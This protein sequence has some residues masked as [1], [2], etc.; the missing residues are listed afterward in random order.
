MT[1]SSTLATRGRPPARPISFG[2]CRTRAH[3]PEAPGLR[4]SSP[5]SIRRTSSIARALARLPVLRK[6]DLPA[7][8][9][10][11]RPSAASSPRAPGS[12][13]AALHLARADLRAGGPEA[14]PWRWARALLRGRP[15]A[16][17]RRPQQ[18]QLSPDA[19]RVRARHRRA[20]ARLRGDSGG[21]GQHRGATRGD[22]RATA[23]RFI[24][25]PTFSSLLDAAAA[26]AAMLVPTKRASSQRRGAFRHPSGGVR[27][28]AASRPT[29]ATRRPISASSPTR[30]APAKG[31]SSTRTSFSKSCG[32][33]P[34]I[35]FRTA[36]SAKSSLLRSIRTIPDPSRRRRPYGRAAGAK[37]LRAH[38]SAHQGLD[39]PR[40]PDREGQGHVRPPRADR[41]DRAPPSGSRPPAPRRDARGRDR[42][43]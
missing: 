38:G 36:M 10:R 3:A 8:T 11:T 39:G 29:S 4:R 17:R 1:T 34:A 41:G 9:R 35:R 5:G 24:G 43:R 28:R 30:R 22:R 25:T 18:L 27:P 42:T 23:P 32:R 2:G 33:A 15:S 16:R 7:C 31:S 26:R 12:F 6:S 37:P 20:R 14:D 21:A 40:R 19:G 13:G